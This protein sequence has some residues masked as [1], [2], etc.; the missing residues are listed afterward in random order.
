MLPRTRSDHAAALE[1][2]NVV[3]RHPEYLGEDLPVVLA[4][5]RRRRI[6][7]QRRIRDARD[8]ARIKMRPND[9]AIYCDEILAALDLRIGHHRSRRVHRRYQHARIAKARDAIVAAKW[10]ESAR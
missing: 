7:A 2:R 5:Q 8:G 1:L 3:I 4:Q 6:S 10:S 9:S